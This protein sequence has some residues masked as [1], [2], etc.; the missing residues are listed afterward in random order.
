MNDSGPSTDGS[1]AELSDDDLEVILYECCETEEER[2][3]VMAA[4][5]FVI[6][7][8]LPDA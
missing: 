8:G 7:E 5:D 2:Y 3:D 4:L 1:L 6:D